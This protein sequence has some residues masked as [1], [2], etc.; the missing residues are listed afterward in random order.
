MQLTRVEINKSAAL[1]ADLAR[2]AEGAFGTEIGAT[3]L[4]C[5]CCVSTSVTLRKALT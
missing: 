2:L 3:P 5:E 1:F 4:R